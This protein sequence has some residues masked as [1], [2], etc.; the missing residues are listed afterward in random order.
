MTVL[1]VTACL[2]LV[3]GVYVGI[4]ED[5]LAEGNLRSL[6]SDFCLIAVFDLADSHIDV[7]IIDTVNERLAVC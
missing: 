5:R 2:L 4:A 6:Q 7:L 1:T 3:L